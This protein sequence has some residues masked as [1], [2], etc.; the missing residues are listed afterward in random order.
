MQ[1][2]DYNDSGFAVNFGISAISVL[3]SPLSPQG[4]S[5]YYLADAEPLEIKLP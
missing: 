1:G 3:D 5:E 4:N 2:T